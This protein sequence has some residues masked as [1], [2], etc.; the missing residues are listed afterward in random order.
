M[1]PTLFSKL[2]NLIKLPSRN[3]TRMANPW[4]VVGESVQGSS[5]EANNIENQ[6][7]LSWYQE[8]K[9][10]YPVILAVSDG[11]GDPRS[12]RSRDGADI[13]VGV[14]IDTIHEYLDKSQ[15][16]ANAYEAMREF[17]E[18]IKRAISRRWKKQVEEHWKKYPVENSKINNQG[19]PSN[20][21]VVVQDVYGATLVAA[22][23]DQF[24]IGGRSQ[25]YLA[26]LQIGDGDILVISKNG[27]VKFG[28]EDTNTFVG[29]ATLSLSLD[30]AWQYMKVKFV[31]NP[32]E[33]PKMIILATDGY[34]K[35]FPHSDGFLKIGSDILEHIRSNGLENTASFLGEWLMETSRQGSGDD[36]SICIGL[37]YTLP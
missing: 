16:R 25:T 37:N 32:E 20:N 15:N 12:F 9:S 33:L 7:S 19:L 29:D 5:H 34:R 13:A 26:F 30:K 6:D 23:V 35:S 21:S 1:P 4:A 14:A 31:A 27:E 2:A 3:P 22:F 18:P 36:I 17:E 11:H 10:G 8:K 24:K 28:F